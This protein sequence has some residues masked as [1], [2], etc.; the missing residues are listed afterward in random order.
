MGIP[1]TATIP[2]LLQRLQR[3]LDTAAVSAESA[4]SDLS[5]GSRNRAGGCLRWLCGTR[6]AAPDAPRGKARRREPYLR[7]YCPNAVLESST[8]PKFPRRFTLTTR[9]PHRIPT[10]R[11]SGRRGSNSRP[12]PWQGSVLNLY[13]GGAETGVK[14]TTYPQFPW[15]STLATRD[16]TQTTRRCTLT[17]TRGIVGE[18]G[19][20]AIGGSASGRSG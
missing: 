15:G 6:T 13:S 20:G 17:T 7:E 9:E 11:D 18:G 3:S 14:A 1:P 5:I 16:A 4:Q 2:L 12:L 10:G 19:G 8:F